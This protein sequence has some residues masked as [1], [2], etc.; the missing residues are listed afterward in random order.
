MELTTSNLPQAL[1]IFAKWPEPG[2]VKTRLSPPLT[3]QEAASLYQYML[4]DT[5][6]ATS[7][8]T[9]IHRM[10][11]FDGDNDRA[12]FFQ[13][14]APDAA[15]Y[16]QQGV[17]LGERLTAALATAFGLGYQ[18]VAI[19]GT[20]SPHLDPQ[21][22]CGAFSLLATDKADVVFG[23]SADGGYYL[24][25]LRQSKPELFKGIPWSS[26]DV[27]AVSLARAKSAGLRQVLLAPCFD[28]DTADDLRRLAELPDAGA[29]PQTRSFL[30]SLSF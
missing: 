28:L 18:S 20:D 23:P 30:A 15:V 6:A 11:F 8:L 13:A 21:E 27:L 26:S 9:G 4:M 25:G 17:N 22:I 7:C 19:I 24:L 16:Q 2:R 29:A 1:L 5:L 14:L 3:K 10:I 12:A